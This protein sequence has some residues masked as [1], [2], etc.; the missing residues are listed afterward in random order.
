MIDPIPAQSS[1]AAKRAP[2]LTETSPH[3][4]PRAAAPRVAGDT[5]PT[6]DPATA[7]LASAD[8][9]AADV[10][11]M[12]PR[13]AGWVDAAG[14]AEGGLLADVGII[15]DL[16]SIYLPLASHV[17]APAV[18]APFVVLMLRRGPRAT[19]LAAAVSS[20]LVAVLAGPHFGWRMGLQAMIGLLLGWAMRRRLGAPT[21]L[22][23]GTLLLATVTCVAA[24][25]VLLM[26]GL[27]INDVVQELRNGLQ[28]LA[29]FGAWAMRLVGQGGLWLRVRPSLAVVGQTAL[30]YW[31]VLFYLTF[32]LAAFPMVALYYGVANVTA[33]VLGF[34]VRAFPSRRSLGVARV[35]GFVV[36]APLL[37]PAWIYTLLRRDGRG[38]GRRRAAAPVAE[39]A[40]KR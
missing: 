8:T 11:S 13:A 28:T 18:P 19:L 34:S 12:R 30:Q 5:A 25:G 32:A 26:T 37:L 3:L 1:G 21:V 15:L 22:A 2:G 38:R 20:F 24:F 23:A 35:L 36:L 10:A 14:L 17:L 33:R 39:G 6:G 16:V 40:R 31:P 27:P 9:V 7:D 4:G 29:G